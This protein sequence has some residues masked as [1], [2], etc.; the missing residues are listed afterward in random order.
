VRVCARAPTSSGARSPHPDAR[1]TRAS[2]PGRCQ[3][4]SAE[5]VVVPAVED[6]DVRVAVARVD[7]V[8]MEQRREVTRSADSIREQPCSSNARSHRESGLRP[9]ASVTLPHYIYIP[10]DRWRTPPVAAR[11]VCNCMPQCAHRC[12]TLLYVLQ[13]HG[14]HTCTCVMIRVCSSDNTHRG[15]HSEHVF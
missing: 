10:A 4:D 8:M 12:R 1:W 14:S 9:G 5:V 15:P 2:S 11:S 7:P 13:G 3:H 6:I